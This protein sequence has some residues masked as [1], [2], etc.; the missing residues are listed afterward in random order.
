MDGVVKLFH[1]EPMYIYK[2]INQIPISI[3]LPLFITQRDMCETCAP[4]VGKFAVTKEPHMDIISMKVCFEQT[5][6]GSI[7]NFVCENDKKYI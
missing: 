3:P 4:L 2:N 7:V 6:Q 5:Q 1:S